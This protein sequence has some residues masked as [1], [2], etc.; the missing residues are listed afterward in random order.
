M[1]KL[2][3]L[4]FFSAFALL[5]AGSSAHAACTLALGWES[6]EPFQM[7]EADGKVSGIDVDL[8]TEAAKGA[9]CTVTPKEVPW[10]RLLIDIEGGKMD[11]AMGASVTPERQAFAAFSAAYRKDE[12]VLFVRKGEIDKVGAAGVVA[13]TGKPFKLGTVG[14]YE[15]GDAFDALRK[16]PAFAKQLEEAASTEL[17]IRKLLQKRLDG[18]VENRFVGLAMA[19]KEGALDKL[20]I[21]PVPVSSDDVNF[22]FSKKSVPPAV[23]AAIDAALVKMKADG[24]YDAILSKYLK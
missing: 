6:F 1:N 7:K 5:A 2:I 22:M 18:F 8:F 16:D 15:Y 19:K 4:S 3:R 10:K 17:N 14:G 20:D 12:F 21:H 9:D 23:V 11:A 13:I 24:R